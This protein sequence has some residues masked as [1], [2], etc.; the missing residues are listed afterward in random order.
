[1]LRRLSRKHKPVVIGADTKLTLRLE[2][3][4][5]SPEKRVIDVRADIIEARNKILEL[6][7]ILDDPKKITITQERYEELL[8]R[9]NL[10]RKVAMRAKEIKCRKSSLQ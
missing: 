10:L 2:K 8:L 1:M 4:I 7:S 9:E 3:I 6:Q 5:G